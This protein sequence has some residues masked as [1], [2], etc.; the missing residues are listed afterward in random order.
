MEH[1]ILAHEK[2]FFSAAFC[3]D[4]AKLEIAL[5][6]EFQEVGQSG[7]TLG[8]RDVIDQLSKLEFDRAI[9][10]SDFEVERISANSYLA[11]YVAVDRDRGAKSFRTSR[12]ERRNDRLV[13]VSHRG[14]RI[15]SESETK[16][17]APHTAQNRIP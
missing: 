12:W 11:R 1:D 4:T 15:A 6:P 8:R 2:L 5:A 10:I 17:P 3:R 13:L 9:E 7:R 14:E 16:N